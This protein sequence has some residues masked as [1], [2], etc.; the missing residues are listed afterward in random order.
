MDLIKISEGEVS[1]WVPNPE[2]YKLTA[3]MPVFFNPV[4]RLNRDVSITLLRSL[5]R[6]M[7]C[8][9]LLAA[10]GAR[11]L[12]IAKE[13]PNSKVT[14]NDAN[15]SAVKLIKK[16]AKLNKLDVEVSRFS[17]NR[18]LK[19]TKRKWGYVDVDP[20]GTPAPFLENAIRVLSSNGIIGVTATD[21]SALCGTYPHAAIRKYNSRS[22]RCPVMHELGLRILVYA[23]LQEANKQGINL[24]PIFSHSSHHYMRVYLKRTKEKQDNIGYFKYDFKTGKFSTSKTKPRTMDHAGPLWLGDLW[25]R[26]LIKR[27]ILTLN[28]EAEESGKTATSSEAN[29]LIR[30]LYEESKIDS[31]GFYDIHRIAKIHRLKSL[32]RFRFILDNLRKRGFKAERTHFTHSGIKTDATMADIMKILKK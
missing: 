23:I 27:M 29:S 12:R 11:G 28:R 4:M 16:N 3:K 19:E 1:I 5:K 22:L 21:T 9:D 10:S 30:G 17:A 13:V 7:K 6:K 8:L 24:K 26:K 32:P 14:L 18:F 2:K 31:I 15:P 20:F 25:E